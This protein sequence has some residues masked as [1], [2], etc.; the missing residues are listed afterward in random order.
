M[1]V[2]QLIAMTS[3]PSYV[4]TTTLYFAALQGAGEPGQAYNGALLSE[5]K[6]RAYAQLIVSDRVL[7]E[8]ANDTTDACRDGC[9]RVAPSAITVQSSAGDPTL[10]VKVADP[11]AQ[12]AAMLADTIAA[13]TANLV[14]D[15][16]RPRG[17]ASDTITTLRILAPAKVPTTP[18]SPNLKVDV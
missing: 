12:R 4:A 3:V 1:L 10:I 8:V 16:E 6:A 2:G 18:A 7:D 11:S 14:S 15:L 5:Q 17:N 9:G 13:K